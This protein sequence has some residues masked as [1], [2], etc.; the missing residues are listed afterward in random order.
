MKPAIRTD[1]GLHLMLATS[2]YPSATAPA[3][4]VYCREQA[5]ALA[6]A[7]HRVAVL[8]LP[9]IRSLPLPAS[10]RTLARPALAP[11]RIEQEGPLAVLR[12]GGVLPYEWPRLC[13]EWSVR[14]GLRAFER[15]VRQQGVPDVLHAHFSFYAGDLAAE[16]KRRFGVPVVLT[17]HHSAF[18][19]GPVA[20]GRTGSVR[21]ALAA[22]DR[23][24][25]AGPA[26]ARALQP[27][28]PGRD[29]RGIEV[30]GNSVDPGFFTPGPEPPAEPFTLCVVANLLANK[31]VDVLLRAFALAFRGQ[32]ARLRI[33]GDGP[34]RRRLEALSRTLG[35]APQVEFL[36]TVSREQVRELIQSSHALVSASFIE[37]FGITL[38]EALSCGKPVVATRSGGPDDL[39]DETNGILVPPGDPAALA[40]AL[41]RMRDG[42]ARYDPE[43][44]RAPI[45]ERFADRV[46][47]GRLE[48]VYRELTG[49][50]GL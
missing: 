12:C 25:A 34:E 45:A 6:R 38:L 13:R 24:L 43:R 27:F 22:A 50:H 48:A 40:E 47:L 2:Y 26:L 36:G 4:A 44:I 35:L 17:E 37:T 46:V 8:A 31:G 39:V 18:L 23:I 49:P 7:G 16:I 14:R 32:S 1:G 28:A 21:R 11:P 3:C 19:R 9:E 20:P 30:L 33:G 41:R 10:L 5:E 29:V 15:Y 42:H